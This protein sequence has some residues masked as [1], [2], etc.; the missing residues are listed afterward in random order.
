[1]TPK[2]SDPTDL[3]KYA[4]FTIGLGR[5][6]SDKYKNVHYKLCLK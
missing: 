6:I 5:I 2:T 1:M 4:F 3:Q